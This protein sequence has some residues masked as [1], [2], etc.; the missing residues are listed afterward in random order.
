MKSLFELFTKLK[1]KY[2]VG[3]VLSGGGARGFAHIG[4]LKALFEKGIYPDAISGVSSGAIVGAFIADGYTPDEIF[5][6]FKDTALFKFVNIA[7]PKTGL[8]K[9]TGLIQRLKKNLRSRNFGE[10]DKRLFV[11]ATD[12]GNAR[13]E[14]FHEG[15]LIKPILA[16]S[17]I[18]VLF[19]PVVINGSIYVDGGLLDNLPYQ[20]MRGVCHKLIGVQV[21]PLGK[22]KDFNNLADIAERT[23]H[24][25]IAGDLSKVKKQFDVYIEP[26]GL[27]NYNI[28]KI[29]K[30]RE[31]MD[32]GYEYTHHFLEKRQFMKR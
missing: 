16:S 32:V 11:V 25:S 27:E 15:P 30:A 5:D 19:S 8:M 29:S 21:N 6:M 24:L 20:P 1:K 31:I 26:K 7:F 23:F 17:S 3:I 14:V 10:L 18:P 22:K 4:V 9:M 12:F 28:L 13:Y 2:E